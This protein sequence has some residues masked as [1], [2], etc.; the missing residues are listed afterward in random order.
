MQGGKKMRNIEMLNDSMKIEALDDMRKMWMWL[1][2]H[3]AHDKQYYV[4]YVANLDKP[5]KNDC[6]ICD[7]A[8]GKCSDCLLQLKYLKGTFCTDPESPFRKWKE[9]TTDNPDSRTFYAGEII[10]L[11]QEIKA[12]FIVD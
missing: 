12:G 6:P 9:T 5:W 8:D 2:R 1:Y 3:P 7:L 11:A 10:A 4:S